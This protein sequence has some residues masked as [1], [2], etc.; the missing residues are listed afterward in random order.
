MSA[1]P[2]TIK[3]LFL[4]S[5]VPEDLIFASQ[6]ALLAQ[7]EIFPILD[8]KACVHLIANAPTHEIGAIFIDCTDE[9][10]FKKFEEHL[11]EEVGLFSEKINTNHF[12]F[13][14]P[15]ELK[16]ATNITKSPLFGNF[17]VRNFLNGEDA[18][19]AGRKYAYFAKTTTGN[20]AF[21]LK[22]Y[23]SPDA[24]IQSIQLKRSTQKQQIIEAIRGYLIKA[25][26][27]SRVSNTIANAIDEIVM[28]S[29]FT[30]PIDDFGN[31][32]LDTT[33]RDTEIELNEKNQVEVTVSF[34]GNY[35]G[36]SSVDLFGSLDKVKLIQHLTSVYSEENYKVKAN[37]ASAG[38]GLNNTFNGGG[39]LIFVC[40]KGHKTEVSVIFERKNN[41]KEF[42]KQ[43][44][45]L[46]TQF[47]YPTDDVGL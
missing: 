39:S 3:K 40:E 41:F 18:L 14:T 33:P 32:P 13:I 28:N 15:T 24:Q 31:R 21:G 8:Y 44:H 30:S 20:R 5:K 38:L 42:K 2:K 19:E 35:V 6:V 9:H 36:I 26:F 27:S 10:L 43:F 23:F 37:T 45:F 11:S 34:D 1:A 17:I 16:I 46:G 7:F 4:L 22:N 47:Y 29:I 25:K 12:H